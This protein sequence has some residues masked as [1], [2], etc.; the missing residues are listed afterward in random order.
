MGEL[1][2]EKSMLSKVFN[3]ISKIIIKNNTREIHFHYL[4]EILFYK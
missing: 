2:K 4:K 3:Y 1:K